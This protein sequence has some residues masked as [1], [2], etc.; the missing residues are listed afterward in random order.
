MIY[1]TLHRKLKVEQ[2]D[3]PSNNTNS[4]KIRSKTSSVPNDAQSYKTTPI[5]SCEKKT[6]LHDQWLQNRAYIYDKTTIC[7]L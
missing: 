2:H 6:I 5:T 7:H 1:K 3:L 4:H